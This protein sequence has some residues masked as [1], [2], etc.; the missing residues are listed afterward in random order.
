MPGFGPLAMPFIG[1]EAFIANTRATGR[2]KDLGDIEGL[3]QSSSD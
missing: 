2:P 3:A 1:R